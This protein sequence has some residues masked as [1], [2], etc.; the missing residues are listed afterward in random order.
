MAKTLCYRCL[1]IY[2]IL[3]CG[4]S[5]AQQNILDGAVREGTRRIGSV[6]GGHHRGR[7]NR[8]RPDLCR[9]CRE[10][11][12]VGCST[13]EWEGCGNGDYEI[14]QTKRKPRLT[15]DA[16]GGGGGG[17][18]G[19]RRDEAEDQT[20][21]ERQADRHLHHVVVAALTV[22]RSVAMRFSRAIRRRGVAAGA[23]R[24]GYGLGRVVACTTARC[25][26]RVFQIVPDDGAE[27]RFFS[28]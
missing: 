11:T 1:I 14:E 7:S 21:D 20:G 25:Q 15:G 4:A 8:R 10:T 27:M 28:A 13:R 2:I 24:L 3:H 16:G 6:I 22:R 19:G 5:C 17:D 23:V 26:R 18:R 12:P 9:T